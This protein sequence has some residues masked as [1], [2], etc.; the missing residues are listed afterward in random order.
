MAKRRAA[1]RHSVIRLLSESESHDVQD[2]PVSQ[3]II[4]GSDIEE[5]DGEED[6][7]AEEDVS[8][9][10]EEVEDSQP[11]D[12]F[13]EDEM[14]E[15]EE[16]REEV[17]E[18]RKLAEEWEAKYKEMQRQM[19]DLEGSRYRKHSLIIDSMNP[20]IQKKA[21]VTSE[22]DDDGGDYTWMLRRELHTLNNKLKN[23]RDKRDI[24][25]RERYLLQ[26]R[27]ETL[28][29]SIGNELESR[30]RLRKEINE[31]NETFKQEMRE[32][33]AE[34]QAADELEECYFSDDED[35]VV[36]THK[37]GGLEEDELSNDEGE[38]ED[39]DETIEDELSNDE[40]E[41]EDV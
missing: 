7:E 39:V 13:Y 16:M 26:E 2:E 30:K 32:M 36:N 20:M 37:K 8:A 9:R 15:I 27:I 19:S 11:I 38:E 18:A 34:Q 21:S 31:M 4:N 10:L 17:D 29:G 1:K 41:E 40:G 24:V 28:V 23:V 6:E 3:A 12:S 5:G 33:M 35:L 14:A 22:Y 25:I